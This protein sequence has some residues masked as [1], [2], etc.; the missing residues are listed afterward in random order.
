MSIRLYSA[1]ASGNYTLKR[2]DKWMVNLFC[3]LGILRRTSYTISIL[4]SLSLYT[5]IYSKFYRKATPLDNDE[6]QRYRSRSI[7]SWYVQLSKVCGTP[8]VSKWKGPQHVYFDTTTRRS[9]TIL[10]QL[11]LDT[12]CF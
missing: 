9:F 8:W 11:V 12:S 5:R 3:R 6:Y 1:Q 7:V 4:P 10:L 2:Q